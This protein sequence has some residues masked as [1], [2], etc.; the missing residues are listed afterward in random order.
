MT[1]ARRDDGAVLRALCQ[2]GEVNGFVVRG[3]GGGPVP[4]AV[5]Q[6]LERTAQEVPVILASRALSGEVLSRTYGFVGAE[7]DLVRRGLT[8]SGWLDG[9]KARVLLNPLLRRGR[10][11]DARA[12]FSARQTNSVFT[13]MACKPGYRG[14]EPARAW[15][16]CRAITL[17]DGGPQHVPRAVESSTDG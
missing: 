2:S 17:R 4:P 1:V 12:V 5:A 10:G 13:L 16:A 8:R 3:T 7:I 6:E 15:V 9:L 14:R 11:K